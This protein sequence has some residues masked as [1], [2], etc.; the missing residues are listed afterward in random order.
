M[1]ARLKVINSVFF[2]A[3][4]GSKTKMSASDATTSIFLT[5]TPNEIKKKIN[6]YAFSGG[7]V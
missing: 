1:N 5:D 4:Q 2:P 6:K 7:Q 3:L